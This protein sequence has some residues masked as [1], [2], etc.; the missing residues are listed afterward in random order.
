MGFA[1]K[2]MLVDLELSHEAVVRLCRFGYVGRQGGLP[3]GKRLQFVSTSEA[4]FISHCLSIS[5]ARVLSMLL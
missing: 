1:V 3:V 2:S 5:S 4:F